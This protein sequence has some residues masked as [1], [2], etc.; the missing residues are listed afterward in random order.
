MVFVDWCWTILEHCLG[1]L[2]SISSHML[3]LCCVTEVRVVRNCHLPPECRGI[4]LVTS[5][6]RT[7]SRLPSSRLRSPL[8]LRLPSPPTHLL[9]S[10]TPT[11]SLLSR[12]SNQVC[13]YNTVICTK[14]SFCFVYFIF[15]IYFFKQPFLSLIHSFTL[16]RLIALHGLLFLDTYLYVTYLFS[17]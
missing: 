2:W 15:V 11:R 5:R 14:V 13:H 17:G 1:L 10:P 3:C 4:P 8:R 16:I 7:P 6:T 9:N 12:C